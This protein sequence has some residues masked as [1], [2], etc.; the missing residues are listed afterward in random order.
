MVSQAPGSYEVQV[1]PDCHRQ[2][3]RRLN[4]VT[5]VCDNG[6]EIVD[7]VLELAGYLDNTDKRFRQVKPVAWTLFDIN[8]S[9]EDSDSILLLNPKGLLLT[10]TSLILLAC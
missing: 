8:K 9:I 3:M 5:R 6:K 7:T 2:L 10:D 1:I 4:R